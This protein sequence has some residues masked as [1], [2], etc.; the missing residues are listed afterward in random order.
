V[1]I[2]KNNEYEYRVKMGIHGR[3]CHDEE[4]IIKMQRNEE[5]LEFNLG[6]SFVGTAP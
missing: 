2:E 6:E 5:H 1:G 4:E 3:H